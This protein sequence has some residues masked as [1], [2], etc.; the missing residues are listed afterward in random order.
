MCE[1]PKI[2]MIHQGK[3]KKSLFRFG[4]SRQHYKWRASENEE[5]T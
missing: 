2:N 5:N 1:K 3:S 4:A